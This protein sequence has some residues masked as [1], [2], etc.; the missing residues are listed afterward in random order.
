MKRKDRELS[1]MKSQMD[2]MQLMIKGLVNSNQN[3]EVSTVTSGFK[4]KDSGKSDV[5]K[6]N[7]V[8]DIV[9]SESKSESIENK[10]EVLV[11]NKPEPEPEPEPK[12]GLISKE[13][14]KHVSNYQ[15]DNSLLDIL[16]ELSSSNE[17]EDNLDDFDIEENYTDPLADFNSF[18]KK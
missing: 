5:D 10:K 8:N 17:D 11:S 4:V 2:Q 9:S 1:D 6:D 14:K 18:F 3:A 13:D 7:S 16:D 15:E 12:F